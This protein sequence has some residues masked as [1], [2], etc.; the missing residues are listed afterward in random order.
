MKKQVKVKSA[1][2]R[3]PMTKT[4]Q[5]AKS[6][7]LQ[8]LAQAAEHARNRVSGYSDEQ[9]SQLEQCARGLIKGV[10]PKQVCHTRQ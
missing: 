1:A 9:R 6:R 10:H 3:T 4:T 8:K 2:E 5:N 7:L